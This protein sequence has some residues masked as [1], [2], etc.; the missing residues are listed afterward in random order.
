MGFL[1]CTR[2]EL[3]TKDITAFIIAHLAILNDLQIYRPCT[4]S[5]FPLV[6]A[7]RRKARGTATTAGGYAGGLE[8]WGQSQSLQKSQ[9]LAGELRSLTLQEIG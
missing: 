9:F 1:N 4:T 8:A 7:Q 2:L 6:L 5:L 3:H